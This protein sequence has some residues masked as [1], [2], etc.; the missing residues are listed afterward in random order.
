MKRK[1][2]LMLAGVAVLLTIILSWQ[3]F[4]AMR[5]YALASVHQE[6]SERLLETIRSLRVAIDQYRYL[7]FLLSQNRDVKQLLLVPDADNQVRVSR[8]LEQT[9]LI[10]GSAALLILDDQGDIVAY[11]NWRDTKSMRIDRY[12]T[13]PFYREALS[14]EQGPYFVIDKTTQRPAYYLSA[15]IYQ[16]QQ[17]IGVAVLRLNIA[18]LREQLSNESLF[19]VS[20]SNNRLLL[21]SPSFEQSHTW[22]LDESEPQYLFDGRQ[23]NVS[24]YGNQYW[25]LQ[26]VLLDDLQWH[27][28]VLS[29]IQGANLRSVYVA[30]SITGAC[31]AF[32]L[33]FLYLREA[34]L[35]RRSQQETVLAQ[36]ESEQRQRHI[37]NTAQVG[38]ITVDSVGR[39]LSINSMVMQQ[40]GVSQSLI[41]QS[42]LTTLFADIDQFTPLKRM[43]DVLRRREF[44]PITGYEVVGQRSD[45]SRFPMLFSIR[46]MTATPETIY[47]VTIIDITRRKRLEH[48]LQEANESLE[49]KVSDR[50]LAL[51]TAQTELLQAEKMAAMGRMSTAIVH[52]LNQP[53]TAMRNYLAILRQIRENSDMFSDNLQRLNL[54][55]DR[56]ASITGQLKT[57]AYK[58]TEV[59]G[60]IDINSVV[61]PVLSMFTEQMNDSGITL[62]VEE[63]S[64]AICVRGDQVRL[65]QVFVNLI[66][67]ACDALAHTVHESP[68]IKLSITADATWVN[69]VISDNGD[70]VSDDALA[71]VFEPFYTTKQMGSGLGLGLS[72]VDNII[73]DLGGR[74]SA[75]NDPEGGLSISVT[76]PRAG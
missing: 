3:G 41:N 9:N 45:G 23:I 27:V 18:T 62:I 65:E 73:R 26:G 59:S 19:Y 6:S 10:A 36:R 22:P 25:L 46:M 57:F 31:M 69:L 40:F 30:L 14:G 74:I 21:S 35:K 48:A 52:E 12:R 37:I 44:S 4:S 64:M 15:P 17:L 38:L 76:L 61:Q 67:N 43:L 71:H 20:D 53:L 50:T 28:G 68:T 39:I 75:S 16:N 29:S 7:P 66:G 1:R 2:D 56:M 47:L 5:N 72:I 63:P 58:K 42:P 60:S 55:V 34:H 32:A 70:G 54:L 51:K 13:S 8:L 11:S 33:L 49:Q 24:R